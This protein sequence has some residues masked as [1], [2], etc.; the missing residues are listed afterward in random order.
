M[1]LAIARTNIVD[2]GTLLT[3]SLDDLKRAKK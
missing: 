1:Q 2:Q 3:E